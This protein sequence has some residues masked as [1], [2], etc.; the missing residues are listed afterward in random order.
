MSRMLSERFGSRFPFLLSRPFGS[1][2]HTW[3]ITRR[4]LGTL[5]RWLVLIDFVYVFLFPVIFMVTTSIKTVHELNNPAINWISR[6]PTTQG[7]ELAFEVLHY[8]EGVRV[9]LFTSVLAAVARH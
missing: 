4:R 2:E 1:W 9:S 3:R 6:T 7:Y 8:F 5:L